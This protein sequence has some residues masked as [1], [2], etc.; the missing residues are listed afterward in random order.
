MTSNK[1]LIP[2]ISEKY[3]VLS[4]CYIINDYQSD[5]IE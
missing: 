1:Y 5:I 2:C 3:F 4:Q